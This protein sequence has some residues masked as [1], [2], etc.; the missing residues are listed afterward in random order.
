MGKEALEVDVP[1]AVFTFF[2]VWVS[3]FV[4]A[5]LT[6]IAPWYLLPLAWFVQGTAMTGLFV[7]GIYLMNLDFILFF[8]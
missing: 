5:Y 4:T 2:R 1:F 6:Y 7:I 8:S 3:V